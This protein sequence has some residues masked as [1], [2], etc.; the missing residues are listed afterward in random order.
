[1]KECYKDERIIVPLYKTL[2]YILERPEVLAWEGIH[3]YDLDL[4]AAI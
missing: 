1:M 3:K 2:D 4:L